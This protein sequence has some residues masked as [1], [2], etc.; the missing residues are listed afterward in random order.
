MPKRNGPVHV[1]T[2]RRSY[3]GKVYE[4]HL[5]RR[6]YRDGRNV[7]HETLGNISHLPPD[8][9]EFIRLTLS[10][11]APQ[12][13]GPWEIIRSLPHG[14]VA[15]VLGTLRQLG[16]ESVLG[17]RQCR[18]RNLVVAM[19]VLRI[20]AP[21]SKLA[22]T[23]ALKEETATSSLA[24][25]LDLGYVEER[26]LYEAMDWLGKRQSRI[27]NKLASKHLKDGTLILYDVSSSYY[28]GRRSTLVNFGYSRD[29]KKGFP[30]IVYGLLCNAEGCPIAIEVFPGNTSDPSTLSHQIQKVRHRFG[31]QRI[32]FVGDRGMITS[33]SIDEEL[34]DVDGLEWITAL[35]ADSIKSLA[36]NGD[37]VPS[38][39]DE[40]DLAEITSED[41]PGE[42]LIVCRNPLLAEERERKRHELLE[43]TEKKL[44]E[45][46]AATHRPK[47]PLRGK[48]KIG[49]RVGRVLNR[50][51]VGK[52]FELNIEEETFS[53]Q[54]KEAN[55]ADEAALDGIY[56]I[57]TC[58]D[59][60]AFSSEA[61]VR[62]YKDLSKVERAFRSLK[63]V[64]LKI[65][66]IYHWLDERI[67]SHVFL[68]MLAYYVEW[69]LR[70]L[71]A[72]VLF[73]DHDKETAEASRTSIVAP[74]PRSDAA[75]QKDSSKRT[76]DDIPVH[77]FRTLLDD[78]ATLA[79]NRVRVTGEA[80][81]SFYVLTQPT[82]LQK[83]VFELLDV[84]M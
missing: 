71:L 84:R 27:E 65:R 34:R 16:M 80:E 12:E 33:K 50:Y 73:D 75:K 54:R 13:T 66:P 61:A 60:E 46:V 37:L 58:V 40:Q 44:D 19:V 4:T 53:Y 20:L 49:V 39:F 63:T 47:R 76:E 10:G 5:L 82:I 22:T 7:R 64:D 52:H 15:A 2:T 57:R 29:G 24:L 18:E 1:A 25:E 3:K 17:S 8:L 9:I 43:A 56:I 51:K 6:S 70:R 30:Q 81:G 28:T 32:V 11:Q 59:S 55:I 78:M 68:C 77:S 67:R 69:H 21:N 23:R 45:I 36:S 38:L 62:A 14:H 79:K 74:A 48:D 31:I 35:R 83:T 26:E 41:F 42:R 72:P